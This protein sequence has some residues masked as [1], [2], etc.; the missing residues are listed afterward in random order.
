M[1]AANDLMDLSAEWG[2]SLLRL[3]TVNARDPHLRAKYEDQ[4]CVRRDPL[5]QLF[6]DQVISEL[7]VT[8]SDFFIAE[9]TDLTILFRLKNADV[10]QQAADRWLA[11]VKQKYPNLQERDVNYRGHR[12]AARYTT[13]RMVSSFVLYKDDLAIF[14]NSPVVMRKIIDTLLG[15]SPALADALDYQYVTTVLEPGD[16]P[17]NAYLYASEAFLKRLTSPRFK[18]AE[19]RRLEAFNHLVMLNNASMFYRLE[20]G[21]SPESLSDLV[22][23]RFYDP[24]DVVDP[25]GGA[26]AWDAARDT[27]TSSVYNRIK[28]LTPIVELEVLQVSRQEQQEY[29]RYK[30]RYAQL[31]KGVFNPV[32]VRLT[33][34]DP[35]VKLETLVLPF[36][37]GSLYAGIKSVLADRPLPLQTEQIARSAVASVKLVPGRESIGG[38]LR[39][40]PGVQEVLAEDPTLTDMTWIGDRMS[41]HF[42]DDSTILEV[43]PTRLQRLE[44]FF[45]V[46][47]PEQTALSAVIAATSL[48]VYFSID[49]EDEDKAGAAVG[50]T[51]FADRAEGESAVRPA[52]GV[53]RLSSAL[54]QGT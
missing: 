3:W 32:A 54:L 45:G 37:N 47:V 10:F 18:I 4:L 48:P 6:A 53:R 34:G 29:D 46:G 39:V 43:D 23:G 8:G 51:Q 12:I 50:S 28:H 9:G 40:V 15:E 44:Q 22:K 24:Q 2:E 36:A 20:Y 42:L 31:W 1:Q 49:V 17:S 33:V 21:R 41:L 14:S 52:D 5:T 38:F 30:Q 13:D 19:K 11:D 26:Y 27:A 7:G 35:T 25:T 16:D